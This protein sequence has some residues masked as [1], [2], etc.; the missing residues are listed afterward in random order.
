MKKIG[1]KVAFFLF[2]L[3]CGS[4]FAWDTSLGQ[5]GYSC[6][7]IHKNCM[8]Y[9]SIPVCEPIYQECVA[10]CNENL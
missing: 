6:Y 3:G 1:T 8:K 9:N 7:L 10:G 2:A 4:A 5:C